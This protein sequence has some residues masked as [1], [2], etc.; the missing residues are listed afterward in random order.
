MDM[1]VVHG[2]RALRGV[3]PVSGSK[4]ATLPMMAA[5]LA[6]S[7]PTRLIGAPQLADVESLSDMLF[8]TP[9][10]TDPK[11][12]AFYQTRSGTH[13]SPAFS[14]DFQFKGKVFKILP[15]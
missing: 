15:F 6:L 5:S 7:G 2:G 1:F 13:V 9:T 14:Q 8:P 10:P 11:P 3:V 4:N 12:S